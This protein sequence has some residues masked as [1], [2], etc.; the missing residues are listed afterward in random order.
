M[1]RFGLGSRFGSW[2]RFSLINDAGVIVG[3]ADTAG[4]STADNRSSFTAISYPGAAS[5]IAA[6][7]DSAGDIVGV[8]YDQNTTPEPHGVIGR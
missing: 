2:V 6:G 7:I 3:G 8:F 1:A 4:F 5:T